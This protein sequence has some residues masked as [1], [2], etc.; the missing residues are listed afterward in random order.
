MRSLFRSRAVALLLLGALVLPTPAS[1]VFTIPDNDLLGTRKDGSFWM[2]TYIDALVAGAKGDGAMGAGSIT[3]TGSDKVISL[4]ADVYFIG[5]VPVA[6][7][8]TTKTP[9]DGDSTNPRID[10]ITAKNDGTYVLTEGT[11]AANPKAPAIPS[12]SVLV[13]RTYMPAGATQIETG[14]TTSNTKGNVF[15]ARVPI[16]GRVRVV[17]RITSQTAYNT[18]SSETTVY[19]YS[20][21]AGL[22]STN[23]SVRLTLNA[24]YLNN[25]GAGRTL[26]MAIKLGST[27]LWAESTAAAGLAANAARRPVKLEFILAN[28][29]SASAQAMTCFLS[30]GNVGTAT[31]GIGDMAT[32]NFSDTICG[33]AASEDTSS[34]KTL[35][36]TITHS[37]SNANLEFRVESAWLELLP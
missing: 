31:S 6:V 2:S 34:A 23:R 5:G 26:S 17:D 24:T 13:A 7:G 37:T 32:G 25:S 11:A 4:P 21:P 9:S 1:A 36:V 18:T 3:G 33:G 15:D 8:S 30:I 20:I 14:P 19:T 10:I 28:Q 29:S 22:L 12:N 27:T 35:V 16:G